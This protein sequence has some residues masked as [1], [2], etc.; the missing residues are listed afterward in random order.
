[1]SYH[2]SERSA[3]DRNT[4]YSTPSGPRHRYDPNRQAGTPSGGF[5][6]PPP[7]IAA[8][9]RPA[10]GW[11]AGSGAQEN[12]PQSP[13]EPPPPLEPEPEQF[14]SHDPAA[15]DL[16]SQVVRR[17]RFMNFRHTEHAWE[18]RYRDPI[19]PHALAFLFAE[20]ARGRPPRYTLK[21]ATRLFL[22]GPEVADLP[23]LL[24]DLAEV[25]RRHR[26]GGPY[27]PRALADR[28]EEMSPQAAYIGVAVS[29]LDTPAGYWAHVRQQVSGSI[30]VPGRCYALLSDG[31]MLLMDRGGQS[32]FGHFEVR[33]SESL[34]EVPGESL[35]RWTFD[36][37]LRELV[38]PATAPIWHQMRLLHHAIVGGD[39]NEY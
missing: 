14:R 28:I 11:N 31:T 18:R 12:W 27:D 3:D 4:W 37:T 23:R 29:S 8:E 32:R 22:D 36:G 24:Y 35:Q 19:G 38:D 10:H 30:D 9:L 2:L 15:A 5:P 16:R 39:A 7:S 21:T 20:Q 13:Y 34:D 17:I 1:M 25:V 6:S 33:A 26:R